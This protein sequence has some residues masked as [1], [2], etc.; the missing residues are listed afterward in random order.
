MELRGRLPGATRLAT[1]TPST[2]GRKEKSVSWLF[3]RKP[4]TINR[5]PK[6]SSMLEVMATALP[7]LSI[8]E[9]W[10]VDTRPEDGSCA[11]RAAACS[12]GSPGDA[13]PMLRSREI[14]PARSAR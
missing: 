7:S 6:L 3:K 4:P 12:H 5:E 14:N 10:L 8:T 11:G 9:M 1:A 13:T 2:S